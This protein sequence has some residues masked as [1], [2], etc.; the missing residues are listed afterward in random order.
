[1]AS[2]SLSESPCY[3]GTILDDGRRDPSDNRAGVVM[4]TDVWLSFRSPNTRL[5]ICG[6]SSSCMSLLRAYGKVSLLGMYIVAGLTYL[7][8]PH[9]FVL[10]RSTI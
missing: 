5:T 2:L 1:M 9:W 8:I 7:L 3:C 10:V 4:S 6:Y